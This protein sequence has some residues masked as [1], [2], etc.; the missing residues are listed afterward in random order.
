M[1]VQMVS[2]PA[3]PVVCAEIGIEDSGG[4]RGMIVWDEKVAVFQQSIEYDESF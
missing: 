4:R 1:R 3:I 2:A